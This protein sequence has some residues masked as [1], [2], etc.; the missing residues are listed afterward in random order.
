LV[1]TIVTMPSIK[2]KSSV[3]KLEHLSGHYLDVPATVVKKLGGVTRA[4]WVCTVGTLSWQCGLVAHKNGA[5]YILL[6]KKLMKQG[7]LKAGS[8]VTIGLHTDKSKF[9][10][11]MPD[12]LH[13]LLQQDKDGKDRFEALVPGKRRYIIYYVGQVKSSHLRVERAVRCIGNLKKLPKGKETFAG[14]LAK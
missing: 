5:A 8:S 11:D 9:G 3:K 13:E 14:L 6:N 2:F 4:R 7:D 12:E 1:F 10:L